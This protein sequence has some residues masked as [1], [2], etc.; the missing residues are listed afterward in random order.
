M[1]TGRIYEGCTPAAAD[2]VGLLLWKLELDAADAGA[3]KAD[4]AWVAT[5]W[6]SAIIHMQALDR[7][8]AVADISDG[9]RHGLADIDRKMAAGL[10]LTTH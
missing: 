9:V 4:L 8:V 5:M 7:D 6:F 1:M 2:A 3:T 10:N